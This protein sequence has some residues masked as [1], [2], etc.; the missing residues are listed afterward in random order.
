MK[1]LRV[2]FWII[3]I[4]IFLRGVIDIARPDRESELTKLIHDFKEEQQMVGDTPDEIMDFAQDFAKEYLT[5]QQ[6]GES[7]FKARIKPFVSKRIYGIPD[8]YSFHNTAKAIYVNAYKKEK[9]SGQYNV[10]VNAEIMYE[11]GELGNEYASCT[12]KIP[13]N[14][15]DTG[16]CVTSLPMYVE[17]NRLDST[18]NAQESTFG[19]EINSD[20]ILPSINNFLDAYYVQDQSMINYLLDSE[21]DK[22][23]FLGMNKRYVFKKVESIK[24]YKKAESM[25][26]ICILKIKIQDTINEEY[27]YQEFNITV[28]ENND[29]FYIK[30]LDTKITGLN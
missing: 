28:T 24:A 5:Y 21:A 16:Y 3:L 6:G 13:V 14:V 15:S 18:Y 30:D 22:D 19:I 2:I 9:S 10:Y 17:D 20:E 7:E 27:V 29:K 8:I 25:D 12:L 23:K 4:F 1:L 11:K 26:V